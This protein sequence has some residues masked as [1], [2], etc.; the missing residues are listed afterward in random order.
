MK[1]EGKNKRRVREQIK[2]KK[3]REI[4]KNKR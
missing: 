1:R 2:K 4:Y 3:K